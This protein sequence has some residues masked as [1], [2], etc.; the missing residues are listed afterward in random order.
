M[1]DSKTQ[2]RIIETDWGY[3]GIKTM[4][5]SLCQTCLPL[6]NPGDVEQVLEA[7]KESCEYC[8]DLCPPLTQAIKAYYHGQNPDFRNLV[9]L[10]LAS[11][12]PFGQAVLQACHQLSYGEKQTYGQIAQ[13]AGHPGAFRAVGQIMARNPMPLIIPCHRVVAAKQKLGGFSGPGGTETK[14]RMLDLE[15]GG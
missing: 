13:R 3:F 5:G 10:N 15:A 4:N 1:L 7:E 8:H 6:D 12:T 14:Q 9:N 11:F 2:A